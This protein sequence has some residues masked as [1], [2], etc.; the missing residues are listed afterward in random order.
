MSKKDTVRW[1]P[2]TEKVACPQV[3]S[4]RLFIKKINGNLIENKA[5][6]SKI[7]LDHQLEAYK[8]KKKFFLMAKYILSMSYR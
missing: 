1:G 6:L 7:L 5:L 3:E 8:G 2:L 4:L